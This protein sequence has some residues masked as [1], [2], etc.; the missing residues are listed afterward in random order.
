MGMVNAKSLKTTLKI[1]FK[2]NGREPDFN[3]FRKLMLGQNAKDVPGLE[4]EEE[5]KG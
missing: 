2:E 1:F 4:V 5:Q 3:E